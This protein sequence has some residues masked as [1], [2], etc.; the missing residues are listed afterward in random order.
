MTRDEAIV[1]LSQLLSDRLKSIGV[2]ALRRPKV[3]L[4]STPDVLARI[5]VE[6]FES[7]GAEFPAPP[8]ADV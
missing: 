5:A 7:L 4:A 1:E 2:E 8:N 3:A 6:W